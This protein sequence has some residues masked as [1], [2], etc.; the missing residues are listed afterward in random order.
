VFSLLPEGGKKQSSPEVTWVLP[1]YTGLGHASVSPDGPSWGQMISAG[2]Q[3]AWHLVFNMVDAF[4]PQR[5]C[6][7]TAALKET[8]PAQCRAHSLLAVWVQSHSRASLSL[9]STL[10]GG[11]RVNFCL[12]IEQ[13]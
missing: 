8:S 5:T 13:L 3:D 6:S 4:K 10:G 11:G 12:W 2:D 1:Q 9:T 7:R